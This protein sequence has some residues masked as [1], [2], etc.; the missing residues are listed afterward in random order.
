MRIAPSSLM[1]GFSNSKTFTLRNMPPTPV[2]L[3]GAEG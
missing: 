1:L 3:R 2:I